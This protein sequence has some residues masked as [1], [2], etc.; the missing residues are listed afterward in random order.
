MID[1]NGW[2]I[3]DSV[4]S[5]DGDVC[6]IDRNV[7]TVDANTCATHAN[8]RATRA[9]VL[10]DT[11]QHL[12]NALQTLRSAP[13]TLRGLQPLRHWPRYFGAALQL[14]GIRSTSYET[15][16]E[17]SQTRSLF[18]RTHDNASEDHYNVLHPHN[19]TS[20]TRSRSCERASHKP[21]THRAFGN[22]RIPGS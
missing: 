10:L 13:Q 16:A 11:R 17:I 8:F 7:R 14:C 5:I 1:R 2:T 4:H 20:Q 18:W 22:P 6:T 12:G 21:R 19:N 15:R 9:H 3:G